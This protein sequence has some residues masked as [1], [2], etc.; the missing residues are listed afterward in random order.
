[1][2]VIEA[3]LVAAG[4]FVP[5]AQGSLRK[6]RAPQDRMLDNVQWAYYNGRL[7]ES[8]AENRPP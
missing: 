6:V 2:I 5:M 1:M 4:D 8:A 7:K 3:G